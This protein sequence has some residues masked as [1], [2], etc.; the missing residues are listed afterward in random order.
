GF[1]ISWAIDEETGKSVELDEISY[2]KVATASHIYAG[3]IG[4]KST[5]IT[6]ILRAPEGTENIGVTTAPNAIKIND[7]ELDLDA[8]E[9]SYTIGDVQEIHVEVE[10]DATV[11]INNIR[12]K[13]RTYE[14]APSSGV[15]RIVVQEDTKEPRI[16]YVYIKAPTYTIAFDSDGGAPV[17][18][19][20]VSE[21]GFIERPT[22]PTKDGFTF[23]EWFSELLDKAWDFLVDLVTGDDTLI[24][25][26]EENSSSSVEPSSSSKDETPSSS[27]E[28]ETPSSSSSFVSTPVKLSQIATG[29]IH[30]Y[31]INKTIMLENL[32]ANAKVQVYDLKGKQ[33]SFSN[34]GN[35]QI[36]RIPVQTKG[37]YFVK[38]GNQILRVPVK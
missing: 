27:S 26:W 32:P 29:N 15:V 3:A 23:K 36:L 13:T 4:E 35:S 19:Q 14:L 25:I 18:E 2:I 31:A 37:I 33:V 8:A 17:E 34:S 5:E 38:T 16:Y 28:D 10:S 30:A 21:G 7:V 24:A 12:S 6:A 11:F 1:D 20:I 9:L 22:D